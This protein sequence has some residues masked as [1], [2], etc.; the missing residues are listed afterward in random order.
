[1]E[2]YTVATNSRKSQLRRHLSTA[3]PLALILICVSATRTGAQY[4]ASGYQP[5]A[6]EP[7]F[8]MSDKTYGSGDEA[9][10]RIEMASREYGMASIE[11][12]GGVDLAVYRVPRPTPTVIPPRR[13]RSLCR[14]PSGRLRGFGRPRSPPGTPP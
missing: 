11:G 4:E 1:M 10:V 6:G 8:L 2:R 14:P 7:F 3:V 9:K 13:S 5:L 12:Y